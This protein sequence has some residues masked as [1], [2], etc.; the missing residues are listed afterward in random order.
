VITARTPAVEEF[1]AHG[2]NIWLCDEPYAETL[3][4]AVVRLKTD[5]ALRERLATNGYRTVKER[6]TPAAIVAALRGAVLH[7]DRSRRP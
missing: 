7:L 3:A 4:A 1:F 2:E 6:F 5:A